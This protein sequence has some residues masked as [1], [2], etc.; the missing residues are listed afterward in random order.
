MRR[1]SAV[2]A[3]TPLILRLASGRSKLSAS[4]RPRRHAAGLAALTDPS[5][6]PGRLMRDGLD[7]DVDRALAVRGNLAAGRIQPESR[8]CDA[9]CTITGT[10]EGED[11]GMNERTPRFESETIARLL[12]RPREAAD[13]L[14]IS[15]SKCYEL[16]NSG[17][18]PSVRVGRSLRIPL[19]ELRQWIAH[20]LN[21]R[22]DPSRDL[23]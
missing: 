9:T 10:Q 14:G 19:A 18:L 21:R 5:A 8:R 23:D 15:R 2:G 3:I 12:L 16:I 7:Q 13:V 1:M 22:S 11:D 20:E 4:L 6:N 17:D